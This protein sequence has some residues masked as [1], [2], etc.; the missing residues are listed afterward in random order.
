MA[1]PRKIQISDV[2]ILIIQKL[3][4]V[5]CGD[6]SHGIYALACVLKNKPKLNDFQKKS[7]KLKTQAKL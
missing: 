4:S 3:H 1:I 2:G 7:P 5:A 6:T